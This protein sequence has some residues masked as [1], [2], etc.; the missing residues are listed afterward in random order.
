MVARKIR[1]VEGHARAAERRPGVDVRVFSRCRKSHKW[2]PENLRQVG[3]KDRHH[4]TGRPVFGSA[5]DVRLSVSVLWRTPFPRFLARRNRLRWSVI[6]ELLLELLWT[7]PFGRTVGPSF[8]SWDLGMGPRRVQIYHTWGGNLLEPK[9]PCDVLP[10]PFGSTRLRSAPDL[11]SRSHLCGLGGRSTARSDQ[12]GM[13]GWWD[14]AGVPR[15]QKK[16]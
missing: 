6:L 7:F 2:N 16:A 11:P 12:G 8:R 13:V 3:Q 10:W 5:G 1:K 9:R 15:P 4:R 14:G